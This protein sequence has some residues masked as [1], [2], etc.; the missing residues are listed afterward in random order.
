[1]S[2]T[3][4]ARLC[5]FRLTFWHQRGSEGVVNDSPSSHTHHSKAYIG[6]S[7]LSNAGP[8]LRIHPTSRPTL[9]DLSPRMQPPLDLQRFRRSS[10]TLSLLSWLSTPILHPLLLNLKTVS[11]PPYFGSYILH[12]NSLYTLMSTPVLL[13]IILHL[14]FPSPFTKVVRLPHPAPQK[15]FPLHHFYPPVD[16]SF[17]TSSPSTEKSTFRINLIFD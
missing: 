13:F 4:F 6:G 1:M 2:Y 7:R 11:H 12:L 8:P 5:H 14:S 16:V 17:F 9:G 3:F 15:L 10:N